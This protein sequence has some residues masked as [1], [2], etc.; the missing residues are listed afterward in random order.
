MVDNGLKPNYVV[1]ADGK[2]IGVLLSI[3][4]YEALNDRLKELEAYQA[5]NDIEIVDSLLRGEENGSYQ[6]LSNYRQ[7]YRPGGMIVI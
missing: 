7:R 5:T 4:D 3:S 1:D 6:D 2:R